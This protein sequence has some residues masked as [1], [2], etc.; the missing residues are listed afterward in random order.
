MPRPYTF[1]DN[2]LTFSDK[3]TNEPGVE[4]YVIVWRKVPPN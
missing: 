1:H 2:L 4:S 3:V